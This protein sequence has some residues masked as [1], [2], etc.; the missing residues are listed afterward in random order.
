MIALDNGAVP[1]MWQAIIQNNEDVIGLRIYAS[2][3]HL[4]KSS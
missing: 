3:V 2:F 4:N 1:V